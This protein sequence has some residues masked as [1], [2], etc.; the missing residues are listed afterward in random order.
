MTSFRPVASRYLALFLPIFCSGLLHAQ[1]NTSGALNGVVTDQSD[2]VVPDASVEMRD[3]AKGTSLL[4]ETNAEG[5]YQFSFLLPSRYTLTVAH[6]GFE[7]TRRALTVSLGPPVTL[8]IQLKISSVST[9]VKVTE[10]GPLMKAANGDVATTMGEEQVSQL[11]NPG[12]DLTYIAQTVPGVVMNTDVGAGNF[13]ILGMP[14]TS[15]LFTLNGMSDNDNGFNI[16]F[17]GAMNMILGQNQIQEATIVSSGYSGQFGGAAGANIN[18]ITK[19]GG[20]SFHGNAVYEWNGSAFNAN[21][22]INK[23]L[24]R[25]RPFSIANQW[26]GSIG[27]PIKR[28][29]VFFFFDTEGLRVLIPSPTFV[30][31]PS[32]PFAAATIVNIDSIFGATSAS[33]AFYRQIFKLYSE[34][35]GASRAT[36]GTSDPFDPLGCEGIVGPGGLGTTVPCTSNF[37]ENLGSPD[38][39][40]I[41]SGR[42]DW[43]IG[44][45]DRAF[46]LLQYDHGHQASYTDPISPLFNAVSNQPWWQGQLNETHTFGP[47]TANQFLLAGT[48][49]GQLFSVENPSQTLSV[50]PTVLDWAGGQFT[51]LGGADGL[52]A[53]PLGKNT[54]QFQ[55]SDD[56]A[57][58]V[59]R[60]KLGF[61]ASLIRTYWS[62]SNYSINSTG[63]LTTQTLKAFYFG[64]VDPSSPA[65]DFTTL[66]QNFPSETFQRFQFYTLGLYAQDEWHVRSNLTLTLALRTEHESNPV[67][68]ARCFARPAGP[69]E[70]MSHDPSQPYSLAILTHLRQAYINTDALLWQPRF[71]FAWQ[72]LGLSHKTVV[73]GGIGIFYNPLPGVVGAF[74]SSNPPLLNSFIVSGFNLAPEENQSLFGVASASNTAFL[75]GFASGQ[76]LAQIQASDPFF[77]PPALSAVQ[78]RTSSPQYQK[79][80]LEVQR[81]FGADTSLTVGYYGNHGIHEMVVNGA[82]NTFGFAPFPKTQCA[83]PPVPPCSDPRFSQVSEYTTE[84][85]SNY[86][87]MVISLQHRFTRWGQ[88]LFQVN[89]TYGHALDDNSNGAFNSGTQF[90][91]G[92]LFLPQNPFDLRG[93]Y[94]AADYDVRHSLNANYLWHV[95]VKAALRGR[96]PVSLVD[97]WQISGTFFSRTGFPYTVVDN[98]LADALLPN[99]NFLGSL[100]GVPVAPVGA[101]TSCGRGAAIPLSPHPCQPPQVLADGIT[102]NSNALFV[103]AGC[104]T[105]FNTGNVPGP[106]GPCSGPSVRLA[107]G[108]N[109]FRGPGYVDTDFAIM[110]NTRIPR[111]ENAI[112]GIGFQFFNLFN[113]PNF[114]LPDSDISSPV[115]GDIFYM[116]R[117]PTGLLGSGIGGDSSPRM[118]QLKAQFQF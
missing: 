19:S 71:S 48:Y 62:F 46:L 92:S 31:I 90:T 91:S 45:N 102:P 105:G 69:F 57:K 27:G 85:V 18:Y 56:I 43:N 104:E 35:P 7:T 15:N 37:F 100:Y 89:Y 3:E 94:G 26:A 64:G 36:L 80:S 101:G 112:F 118:I 109:R 78:N 51:N 79:W 16:N 53:V 59:G 67:C 55:V 25:P 86:N 95:P 98:A 81:T 14:G 17:S 74:L 110:K 96:G 22:W 58:T 39:E 5:T 11:P 24:D 106:S 70:S 77:L 88:G 99:N 4:S 30:L 47:D 28:N 111:W 115:F 38:D 54:T 83:S 40:S 61:G 29:K 20:N 42:V 21:D 52:Y 114:G 41:V 84:G 32:P 1:T 10:E 6:P 44:A 34:A 63:I 87:G 117:P 66:S 49:F 75:K 107:Q 50:F 108:R 13:S 60:Q 72:P 2:A 65:T 23:A 93:S 116:A 73:R 103:Q 12:G 82:A 76:S 9:T 97:G 68:D 8:N 113:H 33:D